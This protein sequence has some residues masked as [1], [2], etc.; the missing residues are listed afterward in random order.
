ML[1]AELLG[2]AR[3]GTTMAR[4]NNGGPSG[5]GTGIAANGSTARSSC[6]STARV[7]GGCSTSGVW[8][9][10]ANASIEQPARILEA[11]GR[12]AALLPRSPGSGPTFDD[13][14]AKSGQYR[15]FP[16]WVLRTTSPGHE[17]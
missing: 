3:I 8:A 14:S 17:R 1:S 11:K 12:I 7:V 5:G 13:R 16:S 10:A 6:N 15:T 9:Q 2:L 4:G